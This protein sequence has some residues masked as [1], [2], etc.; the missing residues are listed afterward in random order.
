[1]QSRPFGIACLVGGLV[2]VLGWS[3]PAAS[4]SAGPIIR[5]VGL[6]RIV[7]TDCY[8]AAGKCHARFDIEQSGTTLTDPSDRYF[9]G[10]VNGQ[11]VKVGERYPRGTSEDGWV[12]VGTTSNGGKTV[13]GDF[14]DGIGGSGTF[15]MTYVGSSPGGSLASTV[16]ASGR[17]GGTPRGARPR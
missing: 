16:I 13:S 11:R 1:M 12:A 3:V 2:A 15:T 14:Y 9:H 10:N 7:S 17:R 5:V 8:F 6:Y 4:A